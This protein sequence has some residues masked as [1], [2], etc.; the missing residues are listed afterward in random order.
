[1]LDDRKFG[2]EIEFIDA[3]ADRV[4]E[5]LR[6]EGISCQY[7]GYNH[8]NHG[9]WKLVYDA[10]VYNKNGERGLELVSPPLSGLEGLAR[11]GKACR[12]LNRAGA[13]INKTCGLHVHHDMRDADINVFKGLFYLYWRFENTIDNLMPNSRRG[14]NNKYCRS[15]HYINIECFKKIKS[16]TD[17]RAFFSGWMQTGQDWRYL[18]L[19]FNA[20]V[21]HGT[22]EFRQHSGTI[23]FEKIKNWVLF[24]RAMI[25]AAF[26]IKI[27]VP[28][29]NDQ[30]TWG[31]FRRNMKS[32]LPKEVADFYKKRIKKFAERQAA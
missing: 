24:T 17:L 23:E 10:S 15:V 7:E 25:N 20:Y 4:I 22:I 11:L 19:N 29:K 12:A 16:I 30:D 27:A 9:R 14:N 21:R 13:K 32:W 18:K 2:V 31:S 1:M 3:P 28:R 26:D 8:D 5:E 6:R